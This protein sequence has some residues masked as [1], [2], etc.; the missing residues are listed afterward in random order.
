M[1][2]CKSIYL[3]HL[4]YTYFLNKLEKDCEE[5]IKYLEKEAVK[6]IKEKVAE[7]SINISIKNIRDNLSDKGH[8][9][10]IS[11]SVA[12]IKK[13]LEKGEIV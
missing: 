12:D 11:S 6:E 4:I 13:E 1:T 9:S 10:L 2:A 3:F 8:D 7:E 5:K